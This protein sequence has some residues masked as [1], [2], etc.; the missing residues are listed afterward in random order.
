MASS[1]CFVL[2]SN[3]LSTLGPIEYGLN[4]STKLKICDTKMQTPVVFVV[5]KT[6]MSDLSHL[7]YKLWSEPRKTE[8]MRKLIVVEQN[9]RSTS[10]F[11]NL[12][13]ILWLKVASD[14][15]AHK[16]SP[17][18]GCWQLQW[19]RRKSFDAE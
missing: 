17:Q 6:R 2:T 12:L 4:V 1:K 15:P 8:L 7:I 14:M 5:S 18:L 11:V 10:D 13:Q 9:L 3:K 16:K 19:K